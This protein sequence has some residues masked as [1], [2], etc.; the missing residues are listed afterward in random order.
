MFRPG[1][2][3]RPAGTTPGDPS[4]EPLS[5]TQT[6]ADVPA[7]DARHRSSS[8]RVLYETTATVICGIESGTLC[9]VRVLVLTAAVICAMTGAARA[10]EADANYTD[11]LLA[12]RGT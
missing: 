9:R 12:P 6:S 8:E 3:S 5:T 7:N 10:Q 1:S 2:I 4:L 11:P